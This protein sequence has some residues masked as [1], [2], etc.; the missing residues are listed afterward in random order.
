M[1]LRIVF[2]LFCCCGYTFIAG[3]QSVSFKDGTALPP[4][5]CRADTAYAL[6]GQPAGGVFAGC[7]VFQQNGNWYFNPYTASATTNSFPLLCTLS[8]TVNGNTVEFP[9]WIWKPVSLL[10]SGDT[11]TCDGRFSLAMETAYAGDYSFAWTPAALLDQPGAAHTTGQTPQSRTFTCMVT[12]LS[13]GCQASDSI[14]VHKYPLP[15]LTLSRDTLILQHTRL[16]LQASGALT[17]QWAPATWLDQAAIANPVTSPADS[18]TYTVTGTNEYGCTASAT[19]HIDLARG[20]YFPNAFSP[21]G[22]GLNDE[23]RIVNFGYQA[24]KEFRIFNR[25]GQQVFFTM[26]GSKGWDGTYNNNP[27]DAGTYHYL[28]R[29]KLEDGTENTVKGDLTLLR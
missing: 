22:D 1:L 18:I 2:L 3:A 28:V 7:G 14:R 29:I 8:Y 21:N 13:T 6:A 24:L 27:A 26:N 12:D 25:W 9:L 16:Q 17:Y 11:A 15:Q 23:F 20:F 4:A 19:V 10:A 5:Y